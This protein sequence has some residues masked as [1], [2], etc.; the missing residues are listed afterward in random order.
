[1]TYGAER[2]RTDPKATAERRNNCSSLWP[3]LLPTTLSSI[4]Y[5]VFSKFLKLSGPCHH[6]A[7]G[8]VQWELAFSFFFES[9][10]KYTINIGDFN[11]NPSKAQLTQTS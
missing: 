5:Q 9:G 11:W 1:M 2:I 3:D 4:F 7:S 6:G 8:G 10:L